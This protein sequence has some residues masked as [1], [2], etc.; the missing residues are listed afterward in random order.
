MDD[1]DRETIPTPQSTR[2]NFARVATIIAATG[3]AGAMAL[4]PK[5]AAA[6]VGRLACFL[7]ST[8][9]RTADGEVAVE[10][11]KIGDL[12]PTKFNGLQ[13]VKWIGRYRLKRDDPRKP[14]ATAARPV[15]LAR[16][17]LADNVPASDLYLSRNHA[18]MIDDVL[19]QVGSLVNGTTIIFD[20]AEGLDQL[21]YFH[22]KLASHDVITAEGAP[23]ETLLIVDE[24]H[25]NFAEYFRLYDEPAAAEQSC[26]PNLSCNARRDALKSRL[27]SAT[28]YWV[29]RR[30]KID[31]IRDRLEERGIA[32]VGASQT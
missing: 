26:L 21:E 3:L 19:V 22:I 11:L 25:T 14:W 10:A 8:R 1:E 32:L 28:A 30:Q 6:D 12:L 16:G 9:I 18:V 23:C 20:A 31:L 13:P 24:T 27:R 5:K 15:R 4:K 17:A 29:D 7:K 2:R